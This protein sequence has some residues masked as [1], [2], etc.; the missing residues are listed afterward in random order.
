[1]ELVQYSTVQYST[2]QYSTVQY[3]CWYAVAAAKMLDAIYDRST[4]NLALKDI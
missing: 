2:V 3:S 1:M 4:H